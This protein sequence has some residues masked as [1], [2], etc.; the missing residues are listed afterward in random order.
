MSTSR[1]SVQGPLRRNISE[2]RTVIIRRGDAMAPAAGRDRQ[3]LS[4]NSI[5]GRIRGSAA[6]PECQWHRDEC[7]PGTEDLKVSRMSG[8]AL[9]ILYLGRDCWTRPSPHTVLP[10][11]RDPQ[12]AG[13]SR[14]V[15][16]AY[17]F[18][19][20]GLSSLW[21]VRWHRQRHSLPLIRFLKAYLASAVS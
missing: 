4:G 20:T 17:S 5:R 12:H 19:L 6:L 8:N 21:I 14:K 3:G 13:T 10:W 2:P 15:R 18:T 1:Q 7:R 16:R 9:E 11:V